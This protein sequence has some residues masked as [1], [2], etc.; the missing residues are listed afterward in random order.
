MND[1]RQTI[2]V[3]EDEG[4][5][6]LTFEMALQDAGYEVVVTSDASSAIAELENGA[7]RFSAVVTDIRMPGEGN[8]WDVG[9]RAHELCKTLPVIYVTGDSEASWR[10][11]GVPGSALLIKPFSLDAAV[12]RVEQQVAKSSPFTLPHAVHR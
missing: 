10:E 6:A 2:L 1:Q 9:R 12:R 3:V 7:D 5:L 4:M 11:N 8:G